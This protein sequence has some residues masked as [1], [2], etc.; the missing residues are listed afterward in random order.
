M[1]LTLENIKCF[2]E[3]EFSFTKGQITLIS[4]KSGA[5]KTSIFN[6]ISFAICGEPKKIMKIGTKKCSVTLE[7]DDIII[8]RQ[9]GPELLEVTIEDKKYGGDIAQNKINNKFGQKN[10]FLASSYIVQSERSIFFNGTAEQKLQLIRDIVFGIDNV[11]IKKQK[12][13]DKEKEIKIKLN[14]K[15]KNFSIRESIYNEKLKKGIYDENMKDLNIDE[16]KEKL[17]YLENENCRYMEINSIIKNIK[18]QINDKQNKLNNLKIDDNLEDLEKEKININS[19]I[20]EN[21][22]NIKNFNFKNTY[23]KEMIDKQNEKIN[24]LKEKIKDFSIDNINE[25]LN[26]IKSIKKI[27]E[28]YTNLLLEIEVDSIEDAKTNINDLKNKIE[29]LKKNLPIVNE[30]F[31]SIV[32]CPYCSKDCNLHNSPY[33]LSKRLDNEVKIVPLEKLDKK[34]KE[35]KDKEEKL[36]KIVLIVEKLDK[37]DYPDEEIDEEKEKNLIEYINNYNSYENELLILNRMNENINENSMTIEEA[38]S[39][40]LLIKEYE[41]KLIIINDNIEK[42]KKNIEH[43]SIISI[44]IENLNKQILIQENL[45]LGFSEDM[46]KYQDLVLELRNTIGKIEFYHEIIKLKKDKDDAEI[47][48]NKIKIQ[49]QNIKFILDKAN[50]AEKDTLEDIIDDLNIKLNEILGKIFDS[51]NSII[52][53]I[54][55]TKDLKSG[56]QKHSFNIKISQNGI[57][58]DDINSLSGGEGDRISFAITI[59]LNRLCGSPLFMADEALGS[60]PEDIK[61]KML[62]IIDEEKQDMYPIIIDHNVNKGEFDEV[63]LL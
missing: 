14:E 34:K 4:A 5:G 11:E 12:I 35:I 48:L 45:L 20:N 23:N 36:D 22:D 41:N 52:A 17:K 53:E 8:Y 55:L 43:K 25:E 21:K 18:Q 6:A 26:K 7:F 54:S 30:N 10:I 60:V 37:I 63:L 3:N 16:L 9:K 40:N 1:K 57:D 33:S 31:I 13:K 28:E 19:I 51:E 49:Y 29:K 46:S 58:Y 47:I 24:K 42:I 2:N 15:D 59:A 38:N 61:Q 50:D 62:A 39:I 32:K 44:D 27:K 56:I